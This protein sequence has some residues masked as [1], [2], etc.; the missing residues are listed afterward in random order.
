MTAH[1]HLVRGLSRPLGL[2]YTEYIPNW[3]LFERLAVCAVC[4]TSAC[5]SG[6]VWQS[7][8]CDVICYVPTWKLLSTSFSLRKREAGKSYYCFDDGSGLTHLIQLCL[9]AMPLV[10]CPLY[11]CVRSSVRLLEFFG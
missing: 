9:P 4:N 1:S 8:P 3:S 7:S 5:Q 2:A 11:V 10:Y 6:L